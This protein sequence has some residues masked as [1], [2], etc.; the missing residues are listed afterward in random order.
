MK[1]KQTTPERQ[2]ELAELKIQIEAYQYYN[3]LLVL[4]KSN[5]ILLQEEKAKIE[6]KIIITKELIAKKQIKISWLKVNP[7]I[8]SICLK[9][10]GTNM[11]TLQQITRKREIVQR[12]QI[13]MNQ[14]YK[15]TKLSLQTIGDQF[16]KDHST[17]IHA[18][19][20]ISNLYETCPEIRTYVDDI[21][22]II[23]NFK[24]LN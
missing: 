9:Y 2:A 6:Q 5:P 24:T 11:E 21:D 19:R 20:T 15:R 10:F 3:S 22:K 1:Y 13:I 8:V 16:G 18:N 4:E 23:N 12:R 14:L 17:V 7:N